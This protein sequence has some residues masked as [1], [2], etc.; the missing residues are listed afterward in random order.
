MST[1]VLQINL[2]PSRSTLVPPG[3]PWFLQ[4]NPGGPAADHEQKKTVKKTIKQNL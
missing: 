4:V 3:Q 2:S 1:Q